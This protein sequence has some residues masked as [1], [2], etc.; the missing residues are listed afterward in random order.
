MNTKNILTLTA[1]R[2]RQIKYTLNYNDDSTYCS[3]MYYAYVQ[4]M[5]PKFC[6]AHTVGG[7][8]EIIQ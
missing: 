7:S 3:Y 4:L 5:A 2:I 6:R 1:N 8:V